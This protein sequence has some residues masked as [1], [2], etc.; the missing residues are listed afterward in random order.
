[1]RVYAY[2]DLNAGAACLP[3]AVTQAIITKVGQYLFQLAC[4]KA[5][6]YRVWGYLEPD[7]NRVLVTVAQ[8]AGKLFEPDFG[9]EL[10]RHF[11]PMA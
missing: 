8:P 3:A 4:V 5:G 9:V 7:A 1:M 10:F 11:L 2:A 6:E